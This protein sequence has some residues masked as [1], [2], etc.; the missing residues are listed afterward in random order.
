MNKFNNLSKLIDNL[1]IKIKKLEQNK[2][3]YPNTLSLYKI[4]L[5]SSINTKKYIGLLFSN[6]NNDDSTFSFIKLKNTNHIINYSIVLK[7][8][9]SNSTNLSID[10]FCS[11]SLGIK[12][13]SNKIKIIKGSKNYVNVFNN[14]VNNHIYI[15]T[16]ILY[17]SS[18]DQELCLIANIDKTCSIVPKKSIL[19][20]LSF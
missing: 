17:E 7:V 19:K 11:F 20:I 4:I 5:S 15:N 16:S 8:D 10:S 18:N 1:K 3:Y 14:L 9:T 12:D 2:K 13:N 6:Y